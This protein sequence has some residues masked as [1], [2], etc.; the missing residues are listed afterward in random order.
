MK[1][2]EVLLDGENPVYRPGSVLSGSVKVQTDR[3]RNFHAI[4]V[5]FK[6]DAYCTW[7]EKRGK[8]T[9]IYRGNEVYMNLECILW[10][11]ENAL[12]GELPAGTHRYPFRITLPHRLPTFFEGRYGWIRYTVQ[13]RIVTGAFKFDHV[14]TVPLAVVQIINLNDLQSIQRPVS[15]EK[16]KTVC[17]C[18]C[19]SGPINFTV[20]LPLTGFCIGE[21]IPFSVTIENGS[22]RKVKATASLEQK[23]LFQSNSGRQR[24]SDRRITSITSGPIR[25]RTTTNWEPEQGDQLIVP[26]SIITTSTVC[27]VIKIVYFFKMTINVPWG[28]NSSAVIPIVIGNVPI[29]PGGGSRAV[30][31]EQMTRIYEFVLTHI[32]R[33][34]AQQ[35]NATLQQRR[36]NTTLAQRNAQASDP[37]QGEP[38]LSE[39]CDFTDSPP[40]YTEVEQSDRF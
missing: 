22:N 29:Q 19:A 12:N 8:T 32:A 30:T 16:A 28:L 27:R 20:R 35:A 10:K 26:T 11:N 31:D 34:A 14:D 3:P 4:K 24:D 33:N 37:E 1:V 2:I 7:S 18:C 21:A 25:A 13:G 17:C 40:K 23:V 15:T 39:S 5:A 36:Q 6:G 38:L 9:Y